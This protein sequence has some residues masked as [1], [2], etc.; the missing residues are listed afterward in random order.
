[1]GPLEGIQIIIPNP[2]PPDSKLGFTEVSPPKEPGG[3]ATRP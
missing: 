3:G 1:M 2:L